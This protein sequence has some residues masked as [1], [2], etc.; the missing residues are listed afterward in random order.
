[1]KIAVVMAR[2][3]VGLVFVVFGSNTFLHFLN[4][5]LPEGVAGQFIGAMIVSHYVVAVG[6]CQVIGGVLL[7]AGRF[8]PLGLTILGPVIVNILLYHLLMSMAGFPVALA[9]ALLW[10]FLVWRHRAN[11]SGLFA[12]KTE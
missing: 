2:I 6:A 12:A 11:F 4:A 1:M 5:P 9:V 7:L 10:A 3:L 8:I